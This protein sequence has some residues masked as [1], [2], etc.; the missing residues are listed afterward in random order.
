MRDATQTEQFANM[1]RDT[2]LKK[3]LKASNP[4]TERKQWAFSTNETLS[5]P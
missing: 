4:L 2:L 5:S 3:I 1:N